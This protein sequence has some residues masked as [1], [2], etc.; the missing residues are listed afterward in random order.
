M[1]LIFMRPVLLDATM[2]HPPTQTT[3]K[4]MSFETLAPLPALLQDLREKADALGLPDARW[5][6]SF[7]PMQ[8]ASLT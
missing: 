8:P 5:R 3:E 2:A 1:Q 6:I 4:P 7:W